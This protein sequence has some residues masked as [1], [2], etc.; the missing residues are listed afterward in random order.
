M[1][2]SICYKCEKTGHFA[3]ECPEGGGRQTL[4]MNSIL[5]YIIND[6]SNGEQCFGSACNIIIVGHNQKL[7]LLKRLVHKIFCYRLTVRYFLSDLTDL[8]INGS[9]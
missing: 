8:T 1:S 4:P 2:A 7:S 9:N 5:F 6:F 3:R